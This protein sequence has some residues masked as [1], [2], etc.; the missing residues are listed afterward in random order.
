MSVLVEQ[1]DETIKAVENQAEAVV[2]DT[3]AG[4]VVF[5]CVGKQTDF[6]HLVWDIPIKPLC[7]HELLARSVGFAS[8][9]FSSSL[10]LLVS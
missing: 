9:L 8:S 3:E 7:Q 5:C 2:N 10:S 1:Q 6:G 4:Y